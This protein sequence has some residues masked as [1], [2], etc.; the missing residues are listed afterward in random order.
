M[1]RAFEVD[2]LGRELHR[3][4][5]GPLGGEP[6]DGHVPDRH[7]IAALVLDSL[8]LERLDDEKRLGDQLGH[9]D[10]PV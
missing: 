10:P 6:A 9:S 1:R 4:E 2:R 5:L 8:V 7:A 3:E